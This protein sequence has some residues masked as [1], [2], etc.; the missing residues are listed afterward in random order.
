MGPEQGSIGEQG[1]IVEQEPDLGLISVRDLVRDLDLDSAPDLD[2]DLDLD[3]DPDPD[4]D[5]IHLRY[6]N[7]TYS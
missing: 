6:R 1:L 5:M 3:S 7:H 2:L 4:L